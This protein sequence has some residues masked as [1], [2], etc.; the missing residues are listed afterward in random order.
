MRAYAVSVTA[1]LLCGLCFVISQRSIDERLVAAQSRSKHGGDIVFEVK[2]KT[3]VPRLHAFFS[4]KD[5]LDAGHTCRDCHNDKTFKKDKKLGVN[6]FTMKDIN[7]GK[8]CGVCHNGK[9]KVK[10]KTVFSPKK[11]CERCHSVKYRKKK[12]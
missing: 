5:H 3:R 2:K 10:G 12:R 6:K 7:A 1:V 9:M 8:A 11:N 4:H